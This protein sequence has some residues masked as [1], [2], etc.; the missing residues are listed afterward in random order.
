LKCFCFLTHTPPQT[1]NFNELFSITSIQHFIGMYEPSKM[2]DCVLLSEWVSESV[3]VCVCVCVCVWKF[4]G[5]I[6]L[7]PVSVCRA[8]NRSAVIEG[9]SLDQKILLMNF[10]KNQY[11]ALCRICLFVL[12]ANFKIL[13]YNKC[14]D[15]S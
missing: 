14:Q 1:C 8:F 11:K 6:T 15:H 13:T 7:W 10:T 12:I 9:H 4:D 5:V 2:K 3:C